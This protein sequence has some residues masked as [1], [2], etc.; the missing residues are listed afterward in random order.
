MQAFDRV[1]RDGCQLL[2]SFQS[3]DLCE[4]VISEVYGWRMKEP[5][6][7]PQSSSKN[8]C[9]IHEHGI[10]PRQ[11]T[12]H[13]YVSYNFI[14]LTTLESPLF[15]NTFRLFSEM[16]DFW[17]KGVGRNADSIFYQ[18]KSLRFWPQI[19]HYESGRGFFGKH[20][21]QLFPQQVGLILELSSI[22]SHY[23]YGQ[24][25][26]SR[27]N[28][29]LTEGFQIDQGDLLMFKFDL[30]HWI[31]FVDPQ[32]NFNAKDLCSPTGKWMAV[33]PFHN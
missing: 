17:L 6:L 16:A 1:A 7:P 33:L 24:T 22:G 9:I 3:K 29:L 30:P 10:S 2:K 5:V 21:H 32:I 23:K 15:A 28:I 12:P 26:V 20:I 19:L 27:H 25:H 13:N 14:D 31:E 18:D 8:S 11:K 4:K